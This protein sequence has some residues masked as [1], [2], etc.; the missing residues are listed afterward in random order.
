M[1]V[2]KCF[3]CDRPLGRDPRR[4]DTRDGQRVYVGRDCHRK[5]AAAGEDGYQ[6]PT[7]GPRLWPLSEFDARAERV[8]RMAAT[9]AARVGKA[10]AAEMTVTELELRAS[11]AT[12][13]T[14]KARWLRKIAARGL[15]LNKAQ[16]EILAREHRKRFP[17][18]P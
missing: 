14:G 7:G 13:L 9:R 15:T 11:T 4:A 17:E 18:I 3:A 16:Q 10:A 6:P 1:S 8:E 12:T 2:D 5:I